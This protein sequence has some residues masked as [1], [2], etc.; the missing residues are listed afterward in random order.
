MRKSTLI[1]IVVT[2]A[3]VLTGT[4]ARFSGNS[5]QT[6]GRSFIQDGW[7]YRWGTSPVD[8]AGT[9][10]WAQDL[11]DEGWHPMQFPGEPPGRNG[12]DTLWLKVAVP[13]RSFTNPALYAKFVRQNFI[14]YYQGHPVFQYGELPAHSDERYQPLLPAHLIFLPQDF[15]GGTLLFQISSAYSSIGIHSPVE[16]DSFNRLLANKLRDDS[17]R[18]ITGAVAFFAG[19]G[20][21]II[22]LRNRESGYAFFG[23]YTLTVVVLN[24]S[25]SFFQE[26]L[27]SSPT[28]W[29]NMLIFSGFGLQLFWLGFLQIMADSARRWFV[30]RMILVMLVLFGI[31]ILSFLYDPTRFGWVAATAF[32]SAIANYLL[33]WWALLPRLRQDFSTQLYAA[34]ATVWICFYASDALVLRFFP[35]IHFMHMQY[36]QFIEALALASILIIRY[37]AMKQENNLYAV[38]VKRK[39]DALEQMQSQL[40]EWNAMLEEMV[41]TRTEELEEQ[42]AKLQY[43][44]ANWQQ[45]F[46]NSPQAIAL[47]D[48]EGRLNKANNTFER[49]FQYGSD[50]VQ[51]RYIGSFLTSAGEQAVAVDTEW[52][53][54]TDKMDREMSFRSRNERLVPITTM[55]YPYQTLT[56]EPGFFCICNDISERKRAEEALQTSE[57]KYR[58]I[59]E[60]T[61]DVI[62][63]VDASGQLTYI[64]PAVWKVLGYTQ[65]QALDLS[66]T[67]ILGTQAD[68]VTREAIR[69]ARQVLWAG[70]ENVPIELILVR[71]DGNEVWT[72]SIVNMLRGES[73]EIL[74]FLGVTRNITGRRQ[75]EHHIFQ[76]NEPHLRNEFF[77]GILAGKLTVNLELFNLAIRYRIHLPQRYLL[78]LC[79]TDGLSN[80][81]RELLAAQEDPAMIAN[82]LNSQ[83]GVVAW[84]SPEGIGLLIAQEQAG[85]AELK[86]SEI[87]QAER[88]L[89]ELE[90]EFPGLNAKIG[91]AEGMDSSMDQ[92]SCRYRQARDAVLQGRQFWPDQRVYHYLDCGVLQ[93]LSPFAAAEEAADYI[94]RTLG[95]LIEYDRDNK[96]DLVSTAEKII[97]SDNLKIVAAELF[98]HHKTIVLRKQR[99]EKVLGQSL[100]SFEMK[101]KLG[102]AFKLMR[103]KKTV[104]NNIRL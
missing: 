11:S 20:A 84:E 15:K 60:N 102:V 1:L 12:I 104:S 87:V 24:V 25:S 37:Q 38:A 93:F 73:G 77:N 101:L 96:T 39:N 69:H 78:C 16:L 26:F 82:W 90:R 95:P 6:A 23:G 34:G 19:V 40:Q 53:L 97:F 22:W 58:L 48:G 35:T 100:D 71:S 56:G 86:A 31:V 14:L 13:E 47:L 80:A 10:L 3:I 29:T 83:E 85:E 64:S 18:V 57:R 50:E 21:L 61:G 30:R 17:F 75:A 27:W 70:E 4:I 43:Q 91:I 55:I 41:A 65:E 7:Q 76:P 68:S 54:S 46:S 89:R 8:V 36:G 62:W 103:M 51:G 49:L 63:I 44:Q 2:A 33:M 92:F 45:L 66:L 98:F 79:C 94:Q 9:P 28:L 74:G 52:L 67:E 81:G 88:V 32:C 72:E 59:A 42:K 99:I 5:I